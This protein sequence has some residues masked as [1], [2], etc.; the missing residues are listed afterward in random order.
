MRSV[1][2]L[3]ADR[4]EVTRLLGR[5]GMGEVHLARDVRLGRDVAL[6][7]ISQ[8]KDLTPKRRRRQER[9]PGPPVP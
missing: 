9:H 8:S 4:Y 2:T 3:I 6:K 1:P 7:C 5:G